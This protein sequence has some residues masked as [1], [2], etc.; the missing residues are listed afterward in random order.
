MSTFGGKRRPSWKP[1][2][3]EVTDGMEP[4]TSPDSALVVS[5]DTSGGG[6]KRKLVRNDQVRAW[7]LLTRVL[8]DFDQTKENNKRI[9]TTPPDPVI[10]TELR[11]STSVHSM[12]IKHSKI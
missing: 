4:G 12:S 9:K 1:T 2:A 10:R 8:L 11:K 7:S 5:A 6:S 3:L